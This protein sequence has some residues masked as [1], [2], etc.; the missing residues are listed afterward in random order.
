MIVKDKIAVKEKA[1]KEM[2]EK[3][4]ANLNNKSIE[5]SKNPND[6]SYITSLGFTENK[7]KEIIDF[8]ETMPK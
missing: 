3:L 4:R 6:W 1:I 2:L 5:Y 7:L 8:F